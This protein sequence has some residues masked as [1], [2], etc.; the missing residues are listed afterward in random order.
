MIKSAASAASLAEA[1]LAAD[2]IT[3]FLQFLAALAPQKIQKTIKLLDSVIYIIGSVATST[4]GSCLPS[5]FGCSGM[6]EDVIS[7]KENLHQPGICTGAQV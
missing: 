1:A 4:G 3:T 2:W 5:E 6:P 7:G